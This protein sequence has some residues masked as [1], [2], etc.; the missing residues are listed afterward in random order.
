MQWH[1]AF[2][3][4]VPFWLKV[5]DDVVVNLPRMLHW[6]RTDFGPSMAS[7]NTAKAIF[8]R[9]VTGEVRRDKKDKW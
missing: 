1:Q 6:I 4:T 5:D 8:G 7:A 2:Y 9:F 3:P